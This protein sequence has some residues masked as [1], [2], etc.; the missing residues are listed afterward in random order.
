MRRT[1][2]TRRKFKYETKPR[3]K[4]R[5][6]SYWK[7]YEELVEKANRQSDEI[8]KIMLLQQAEHYAKMA[9]EK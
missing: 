8:E 4:P 2:H 7:K 1:E 9:N 5:D 6:N 3:H